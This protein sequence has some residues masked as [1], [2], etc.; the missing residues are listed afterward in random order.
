MSMTWDEIE[1]LR[2]AHEWRFPLPPTCRKCSYN[3]TGLPEDRCPECGTPFTWR[4]VR[5]RVGR[6]WGLTLRL[7][8]ANQDA[9]TGLILS[10]GGWFT[11]GF[12]ALV[13]GDILVG[14]AIIL[15]FLAGLLGIVLGSQVLNIRRV[16][17]WARKYVADPPPSMALGGLTMLLSFA[18]FLG[19][20][21]LAA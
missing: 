11:L 2:P 17:P 12:A 14:L 15:A 20:I 7:R 9:M 6:I 4:E 19:A 5:Q 10:L 13:G 3:L 1:R 21:A 18:L 16:P 8:H